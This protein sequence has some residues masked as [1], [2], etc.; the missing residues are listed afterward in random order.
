M[1]FLFVQAVVQAQLNNASNV[2][3]SV[4][5]TNSSGENCGGSLPVVTSSTTSTSTG[6]IDS[7]SYS[8]VIVSTNTKTAV[9]VALTTSIPVQSQITSNINQTS[10]SSTLGML[11]H[12]SS[13][14]FDQQKQ[15]VS[16]NCTSSSVPFSTLNPL[17]CNNQSVSSTVNT[18]L[19]QQLSN[20]GAMNSV[21]YNN[22]SRSPS[23]VVNLNPN[24]QRIAPNSM[25]RSQYPTVVSSTN[26]ISGS[27]IQSS[28]PNLQ[29]LVDRLNESGMDPA[30]AALVHA[31]LTNGPNRR[32]QQQ[33][34]RSSVADNL[35]ESQLSPYLRQMVQQ[36]LNNRTVDAM[37][38]SMLT[39]ATSVLS[40]VDGIDST[41]KLLTGTRPLEVV[42]S[43]PTNCSSMTSKDSRLNSAVGM[44]MVSTT[45][46]PNSSTI[47]SSLTNS[48]STNRS[49]VSP[50]SVNVNDLN[51]MSVGN[52]GK[53]TNATFI[54]PPVGI[55]R[56]TVVNS[57]E[58]YISKQVLNMTNPWISIGAVSFEYNLILLV[59]F[60]NKYYY[61][62]TFFTNSRIASTSQII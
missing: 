49:F 50:L 31:A 29:N 45:T 44:M 22:T 46:M 36:F 13:I 56:S 8:S 61:I 34:R 33:I 42:S 15:V 9:T 47:I 14:T 53:L 26:L 52:V 2:I 25:D 10:L 51:D 7:I 62:G 1:L 12:S 39:H 20:C 11:G 59:D 18:V 23:V 16:T 43:I 60:T 40:N 38:T 6:V 28:N 58:P 17:V 48:V 27:S 37:N 19:Q 55:P 3:N 5:L 4:S 54:S 35:N 24:P 41:L 32:I 30:V 57:S 21:S